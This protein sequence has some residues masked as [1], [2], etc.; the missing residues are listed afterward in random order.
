[1]DLSIGNLDRDAGLLAEIFRIE[2]KNR[3]AVAL[4][5]MA[6]ASSPW[7][8]HRPAPAKEWR[9]GGKN[10]ALHSDMGVAQN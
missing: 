8:L 3:V 1:M 7:L 5:S 2:V 9:T 4:S 6:L 10:W